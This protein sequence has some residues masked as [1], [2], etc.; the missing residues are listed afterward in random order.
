MNTKN[1]H[2]LNRKRVQSDTNWTKVKKVKKMTG[3]LWR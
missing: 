2:L 3:F 1:P